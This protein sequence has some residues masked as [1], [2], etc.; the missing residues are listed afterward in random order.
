MKKGQRLNYAEGRKRRSLGL[1]GSRCIFVCFIIIIIGIGIGPFREFSAIS[2]AQDPLLQTEKK[3]KYD[4][5]SSYIIIVSISGLKANVLDNADRDR[6]KIPAIRSLL[7]KGARAVAVESVYPSLTNPAHAS[8]ATGVYPADHGITSDFPFNELTGVQADEPYWLAKDIK[9]ETLWD[10]AKRGGFVTAAVGY[11]LTAGAAIDFNLPLA[12][13][14]DFMSDTD[15]AINRLLS[16]QL[17]NPP[18]LLDKLGPEIMNVPFSVDKKLKDIAGNQRIDQLK[19]D[20]AAY[21][22]ENHQ[23]NLLMIN[24][25][26]Y[27]TALRRYGTQSREAMLA[28]EFIDEQILKIMKPAEK[29]SRELTFF[30]ISDFGLLEIDKTFN[31]NAVLAKKGWLST[32]GKGR[33]TAWRAI[34]QTYGGS[35]AIFLRDSHDK[36]TISEIQD[37]FGEIY[38]KPE[39]PI[40]QI[41]TAQDAAKLGADP[42]AVLY[43]EAA[44][45]YAMTAR[46]SGPAISEASDRAACGYL[47]SRSEMFGIFIASGKG[48]IR[49]A[50]IEYGRLIDVA[51]T[52]ARLLGLEMRTARGRVYTEVISQ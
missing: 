22:I 30:V 39:S 37:F 24:L 9:T 7:E 36:K 16:K 38:R 45:A 20:T 43:L 31:P 34:A 15:V 2:T 6:L 19:A 18:D 5:L 23:P 46:A 48:I 1:S 26:S 40:W 41:I 12:F 49:G 14:T 47:P 44:P 10:A 27:A 32:A 42:R 50:K 8:I 3:P 11:P 52:A 29:L 28:L 17:I 35:A 25:D 21:I 51:P 33:I 4:Q 13:A